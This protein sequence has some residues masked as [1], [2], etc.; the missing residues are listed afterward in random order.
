MVRQIAQ[1]NAYSTFLWGLNAPE[2]RR[3]WPKRLKF[4]LDFVEI[5]GNTIE[6]RANLLYDIIKKEGSLWLQ[7]QLMDFVFFQKR[8]VD[9]K[10]IAEST[11][12]NYFKP[13]KLFCDMN[14]V[15][16][17]WK[18]VSKVIPRYYY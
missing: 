1:T 15:L 12:S 4:F 13:I 11:V 6:D 16:I 8:R 14:N 3:Q 7:K 18:L 17:D 2:T 5:I 10:E 9:N